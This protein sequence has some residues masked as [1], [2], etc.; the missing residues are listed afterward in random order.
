MEDTASGTRPGPDEEKRPKRYHSI[1]EV[2]ELLDVRPHV[3]RYWETQFPALRPKK[4]RG[5]AR[6]YQERDLDLLRSIKEMLYERGYT[7]AGARQ[8]IRSEQRRRPAERPQMEMDFL[9]PSDRR[10]LRTIRDELVRLRNWLRGSAAERGSPRG[11]RPGPP[12]A[13]TG[14]ASRREEAPRGEPSGGVARSGTGS[15]S[16]VPQRN[17]PATERRSGADPAGPP[18]GEI[19]VDPLTAAG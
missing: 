1:S 14:K 10:Q 6:R 7:I 9:S 17:R 15:A 12:P 2:S 13:S 11:P 3:L 4:S 8:R 19:S 18:A 5:G 16:D